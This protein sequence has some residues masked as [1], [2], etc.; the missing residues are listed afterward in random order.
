[1]TMS[2]NGVKF[3]MLYHQYKNPIYQTLLYL[4]DLEDQLSSKSRDSGTTLTDTSITLSENKGPISISVS[5]FQIPRTE[6]ERDLRQLMETFVKDA[7]E[8]YLKAALGNTQTE[9]SPPNGLTNSEKGVRSNDN[10]D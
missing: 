9:K 3:P 10:T 1:M 8:V 5:C 2:L 4:R 7:E 6:L